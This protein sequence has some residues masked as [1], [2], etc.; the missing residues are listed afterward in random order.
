MSA[1]WSVVCFIR[2]FSINKFCFRIITGIHLAKP[3]RIFELVI[4]ERKLLAYGR[5]K[6]TNNYFHFNYPTWKRAHPKVKLNDPEAR[7][8]ID[9]HT[10]TY[11]NRS[12]NFDTVTVPQGHVV[13][14][15][16]FGLHNGHLRLEVRATEFDFE[17]GTLMNLENS[18]WYA[19]ENGGKYEIVL[20]KA[21]PIG[22]HG[23][24]IM[25]TILDS[26]VQ[27]TPS[28]KEAD[29]AQTIVPF[30]DTAKVEP[31]QPVP[32]SGLGLYYKGKLIRN[33][34]ANRSIDNNNGLHSIFT[35]KPGHSGVIAPKL[36]VYNFETLL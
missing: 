13:T 15:V 34:I 22:L 10:L 3:N 26:Y 8:G 2:E 24:P 5:L 1:W 7:D 6:P 33:V 29:A 4:S 21:K 32:L 11:E 17:T 19:N 14:G 31:I 18:T 23:T 16:R 30:L 27:F 25:N 9:Y 12:I 35:G 28:D 36:I 20:K